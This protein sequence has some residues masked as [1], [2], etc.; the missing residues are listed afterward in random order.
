[1]RFSILGPV[2][3]HDDARAVPVGGARLRALLVLLLLD[4]GRTVGTERLIGGIW[5]DDAPGGAGNALQALVSRLRRLLG[6]SVPVV[7][8]ATGYRL[9]AAPGQVDL[10]EFEALVER[11]RAARAAGDPREAVRALETAL[12][13]WTGPALADVADLDGVRSVLVRLAEL[14]RT[15]AEDRLAAQLDLG[16]HAEALPDIEALAA[17]Q[18]LGERPVRLLMRALAGCGRQADALAAYDA[19]RRRL[20]EEF[21]ADPATETRDL[22][23]RL[24]RGEL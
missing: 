3:V 23:L 10:W 8:D 14:R 6:D 12:A 17:E 18:P 15:A 20:A 1:M 2:T 16:R 5:G 24:L 4:P 21:G 11:G 22:H 9:V 19:L 7:A 13:L